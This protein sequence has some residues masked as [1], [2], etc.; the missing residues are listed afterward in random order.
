MKKMVIVQLFLILALRIL[1]LSCYD[2][3]YTT[4]PNGT[5]PY[6]N[7]SV[8]V[9]AIVVAECFYTGT[10][11]NNY[12]YMLGDAEGGPWSGLFIFDNVHHPQR[13]DLVQVTGFIQE[14]YNWTEMT[15]LT[16]YAVLSHNNPLP[17]FTAITT[18]QLNDQGEQWENVLVSVQNVEVT[19]LTNNYGEFSVNDGS[20]VASINDQCFPRPGYTWPGLSL[21]QIYHQIRGVVAESF[22]MYTINPR[23]TFDVMQVPI[24]C[25]LGL[26]EVQ[27]D[28]WQ[29][30]GEPISVT[31]TVHNNTDLASERFDLVYIC[32]EVE[33]GRQSYP[34]L[35]A[36]QSLNLSFSF[37]PV[38]PGY[39][40]LWVE[41]EIEGDQ[42]PGNNRFL[43]YL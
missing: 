18:G 33:V 43:R 31:G 8:T 40:N 32:N 35:A 16:S 36:D 6:T 9:E 2:V 23:D 27:V 28:F 25:D 7:Q 21:G 10:S 1:A 20:G 30:M 4:N 17:P 22:S 13:G 12:G 29:D 41:L 38:E 34:G 19:S 14:Y 42:V 37:N 15:S 5:S 39:K 24:T 11:S 26:N 3:Q